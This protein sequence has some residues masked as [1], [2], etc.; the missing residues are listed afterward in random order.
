MLGA[1]GWWRGV[2]GRGLADTRASSER[3][4]A[5]QLSGRQRR[6]VK[7]ARELRGETW[8]NETQDH[9]EVELKSI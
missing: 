3:G 1:P 9:G 2:E 4:C 6:E 5:A 7:D 8:T